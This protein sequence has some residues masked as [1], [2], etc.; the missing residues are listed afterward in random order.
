MV[1]TVKYRDNHCQNLSEIL[2]HGYWNLKAFLEKTCLKIEGKLW[3]QG[4]G[5]H[6]L[7]EIAVS[8]MLHITV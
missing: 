1:S 8:K 5:F 6:S 7:L 3:S 2:S 4:N